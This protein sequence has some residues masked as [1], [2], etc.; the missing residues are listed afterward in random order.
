MIEIKPDVF[1]RFSLVPED[2]GDVSIQDIIFFGMHT[3]AKCYCPGVEQEF[4]HT[5]PTGHTLQNPILFS[6]DGKRREYAEQAEGWLANPLIENFLSRHTAK[7][8]PIKKHV[9]ANHRQV[10]I[11]NCLDN[12]Y[13]HCLYKLFNAQRH[14]L[15]HSEFG[16]ILLIPEALLWL[17][18]EGVAE[19][20][21]VESPVRQLD[22]CIP[23][24]DSFVKS[25]IEAYDS[26]YL[27]QAITQIN[28]SEVYT[29]RFTKTAPFSIGNFVQSNY[30]ITFVV[31]EDRFWLDNRVDIFL[32]LGSIKFRILAWMKFYFVYKQNRLI[33]KAS[34]YIKKEIAGAQFSVVGIERTGKL[35]KGLTDCRVAG[36]ISLDQEQKWAYLYSRSHLVIGV[37]GSNMLIP[38]SLAAGSIVLMPNHKIAHWGEDVVVRHTAA[39]T[40]FLNRFLPLSSAKRVADY[41]T[42]LINGFSQHCFRKESLE[43]IAIENILKKE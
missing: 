25:S 41:A 33:K 43:S 26:V 15:H 35:G 19:V 39:N 37:H 32:H 23:D 34:E 27:S 11:L 4:Y 22:Q 1:G 18:P 40:T 17:V 31:R 7:P 9:Y 29:E 30:Q 12:C 28:T 42:Q 36:K 2:C 8:L 3:L 14:L 21:C 38:T 6:E 24:L 16:L 5:F 13:G 10:I 20:W